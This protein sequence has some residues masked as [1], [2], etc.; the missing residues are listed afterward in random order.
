MNSQETD[1]AS[2]PFFTLITRM[3]KVQL[4][5]AQALHH[6]SDA[7]LLIPVVNTRLQFKFQNTHTDTYRLGRPL[8][9]GRGHP[10]LLLR[11]TVPANTLIQILLQ[12]LSHQL[13]HSVSLSWEHIMLTLTFS[14]L[15]LMCVQFTHTKEVP[16]DCQLH[17]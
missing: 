10:A 9:R 12:L 7:P 5:L 2:A 13:H 17:P 1:R 6:A 14:P 11:I 15:S 16:H 8:R 3:F 4:Q